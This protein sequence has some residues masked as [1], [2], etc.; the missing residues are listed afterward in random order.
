MQSDNNFEPLSSIMIH[1]PPVVPDRKRRHKE[2]EQ[3]GRHKIN[4]QIN[5]LKNLLPEC[6]Y[7]N[8]TKASVLECAVN[9]IQRLQSLCNA[10]LTQNKALLQ[11]NKRLQT[12]LAKYS[13]SF[14]FGVDTPPP[15]EFG[16]T[17]DVLGVDIG[18]IDKLLGSTEGTS[19]NIFT[20]YSSPSSSPSFDS[21]ESPFYAINETDYSLPFE[22]DTI[23]Y[24]MSKRR[25]LL[26]FVFLLPF[27]SVL[28]GENIFSLQDGTSTRILNG[29]PSQH[30]DAN[31][32]SYIARFTWLAVLAVVC[33]GW[34][35][36]SLLWV[37]G[38][39]KY[40]SRTYFIWHKKKRTVSSMG[41][42]TSL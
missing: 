30:V 39:G 28:S 23:F 37:H 36:H 40:I 4:T 19:R 5:D 21:P 3:R 6:K 20:E 12:E 15:N 35:T 38:F 26:V 2:T 29:E 34:L 24:K 14:Q 9:S 33:I 8:T 27:F 11:D 32:Y 31:P 10:L 41:K 16:D 1:S 25:L 17:V 13:P 7:V 22:E 18:E 42:T